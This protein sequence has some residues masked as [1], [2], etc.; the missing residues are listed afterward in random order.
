MTVLDKKNDD[1]NS[2]DNEDTFFFVYSK[3]GNG[4]EKRKRNEKRREMKEIKDPILAH[5]KKLV[6]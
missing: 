2:Y 1:G 6:K 4:G 3:I 5:L